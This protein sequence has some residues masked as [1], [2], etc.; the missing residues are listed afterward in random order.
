MVVSKGN[1]CVRYR[2]STHPLSH[3][4]YSRVRSEGAV[5]ANGESQSFPTVPANGKYA[6]QS[7]PYEVPP[8][9][10]SAGMPAIEKIGHS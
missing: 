8:P 6:P 10:I 2:R 9:S 7:G 5:S 4:D 1:I 3:Q